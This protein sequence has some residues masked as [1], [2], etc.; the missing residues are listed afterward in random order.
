MKA[1]QI[2]SGQSYENKKG[3]EIRLVKYIGDGNVRYV[4]QLPEPQK[5]MLH[6]RRVTTVTTKEFAAW[7]ARPFGTSKEHSIDNKKFL[8]WVAG[9]TDKH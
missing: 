7:A 2:S 3:T 6:R 9:P 8:A 5:G 4:E 1:S